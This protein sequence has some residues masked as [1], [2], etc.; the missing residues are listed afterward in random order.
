MKKSEFKELVREAVIEML[1]DILEIVMENINEAYGSTKS[2]KQKPDLTLVRQHVKEA[3]GDVGYGDDLVPNVAPAPKKMSGVPKP[4]NPKEEINGEVFASGK[5]IMEWFS[6]QH[7]TEVKKI[8]KKTQ[9]NNDR[10][11]DFIAK[12]FGVK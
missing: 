2:V 8:E 11:D 9:H 3:A 5:G 6:G 1:P 4:N 12:K 10:M 7:G